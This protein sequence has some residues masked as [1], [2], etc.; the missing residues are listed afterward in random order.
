VGPKI[1]LGSVG[2][3]GGLFLFFGWKGGGGVEGRAEALRW[4]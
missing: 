2:G 3:R 1:V 4:D